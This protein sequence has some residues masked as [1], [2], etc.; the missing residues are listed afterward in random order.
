MEKRQPIKTPIGIFELP[1]ERSGEMY[2]EKND[3][4]KT[5]RE[6]FSK[7]LK[8]YCNV[9]DIGAHIGYH[10]VAL[11]KICYDG[12]VYCFEPNENILPFLIKNISDNFCANVISSPCAV[13]DSDGDA[14][15]DTNENTFLNGIKKENTGKIVKTVSLDGMLGFMPKISLIKIDT[16]GHE[17]E[18]LR[19]AKK[20]LE[21]DKPVLFVEIWRH[22]Y[23]PYIKY[24][25][26]IGYSVY[27]IDEENFVAT[28]NY[29]KLNQQ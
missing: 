9:I 15:F 16:E 18:V 14:F 24:L 10:T 28:Y 23:I 21:R 27:M 17:L 7:F 6:E 12:R 25:S 29:F 22:N 8:P 2:A 26:E 4:E 3:W 1:N 20:L 11:P 5:I 13:S 19:G